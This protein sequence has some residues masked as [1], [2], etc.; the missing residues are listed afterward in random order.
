MLSIPAR[1]PV[2]A[3]ACLAASP[4]APT[5]A[6]NQRAESGTGTCTIVNRNPGDSLGT[7]FRLTAVAS[8]TTG[9]RIYH[10]KQ[11]I[12]SC[13]SAVPNFTDMNTQD[14]Y[15]GKYSDS[16][17]PLNGAVQD[18]RIYQQALTDAEVQASP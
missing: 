7:W 14:L 18:I 15:I 10:N 8:T 17:Y 3:H 1:Y 13:P 16:W 5:P 4:T 12:Y 2:Q 11:L 9:T 6:P